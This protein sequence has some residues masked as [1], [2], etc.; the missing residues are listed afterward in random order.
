MESASHVCRIQLETRIA[1]QFEHATLHDV[2][3]PSKEEKDGSFVFRNE[4]DSMERI[5]QL[6]L[7][8]FRGYDEG[9]LPDMTIISAVG[10]LWDE[11]LT[12]IACGSSLSPSRFA[13]LVDRIP[14]YMR[15][16]HDH[17]YRAIH[18]YLKVIR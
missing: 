8:R 5:L 4:L 11:Y 16:V 14:A 9:R 3:L 15:V 10:K 6:F 2:L 13:E 18:A 12:D 1:L 7:T 17:V